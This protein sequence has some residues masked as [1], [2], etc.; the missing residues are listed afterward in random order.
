MH[1]D[2]IGGMV[3]RMPSESTCKSDESLVIILLLIIINH[4]YYG[5][6]FV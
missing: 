4:Y 6:Q 1:P 3:L 2:D 5:L